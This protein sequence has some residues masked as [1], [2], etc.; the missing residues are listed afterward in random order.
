[1][2]GIPVH[3]SGD[4]A[5]ADGE[6]RPQTH[7]IGFVLPPDR[8]IIWRG[9]MVDR[10]LRQFL[11]E[12]PWGPLDYLILDMPPGTGDAQLT[13]TQQT[14]LTGAVIVTTP[15][16]VSLIDARKG[17]EMFREV[18][19]P[20]AGI[21]ENMSYFLGEDGKRYEIFRHG[22]GRARRGASVPFLARFPSTRASPSAVTRV[23]RWSIAIRLADHGVVPETRRVGDRTLDRA[24]SGPEVAG[25][26]DVRKGG[27]S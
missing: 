10:Y 2:L 16:D 6:I 7:V 12:L 25:S 22:A 21:I 11:T 18:R 3:R 8:A 19:R 1:M 27:T 15:Q 14:N 17:L 24:D 26:A 13:I 5:A 4:H 9:P 23:S 20:G